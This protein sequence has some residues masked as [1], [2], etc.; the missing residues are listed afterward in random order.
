MSLDEIKYSITKITSI[1][2]V[3]IVKDGCRPIGRAGT[4]IAIVV[5]MTVVMLSVLV[6]RICHQ[7]LPSTQAEQAVHLL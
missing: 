2:V 3:V 6:L 7:K 4:V 5:I 1:A